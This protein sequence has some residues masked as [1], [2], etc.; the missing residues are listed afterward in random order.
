[1]RKEEAEQEIEEGDLCILPHEGW[2]DEF[3]DTAKREDGTVSFY[4]HNPL[5]LQISNTDIV[6]ADRFPF[7]LSL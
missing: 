1:M 6:S 5:L 4:R 3:K 7:P 2:K